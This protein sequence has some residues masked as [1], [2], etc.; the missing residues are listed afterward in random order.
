MKASKLENLT[1][2]QLV[3]QFAEIALAQDHAIEDDENAKYNRLY[4]EMDAVRGELKRR[5]GDQRRALLPLLDHPNVHLRLKAAISTLAVAPQE[6]RRILEQI[7]ASGHYPQAAD[8]SFMIS[9]LDDG[10]YIPT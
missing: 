2:T 1:V 4:S 6:A 5:H 10:S 9:G 8:A 3:Q 7:S